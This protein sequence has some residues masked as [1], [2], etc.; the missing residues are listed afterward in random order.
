[1]KN[2]PNSEVSKIRHNPERSCVACRAKKGK[3]ELIRLV[4]SSNKVEVDVQAKIPG[5]GAYLCSNPECWESGIGQ[6]RLDHAL[7][8]KVSNENRQM[9]IEYA[10]NLTGKET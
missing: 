5:R 8:T 3:R 10:R 6:N 7:R 9:L 4:C 2:R 1:L